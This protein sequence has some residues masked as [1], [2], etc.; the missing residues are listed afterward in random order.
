MGEF[1]ICIGLCS[2]INIQCFI[3]IIIIIIIIINERLI[4]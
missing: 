3:I 2:E 4:V 1:A